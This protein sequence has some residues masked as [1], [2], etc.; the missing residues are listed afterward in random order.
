MEEKMMEEKVIYFILDQFG[1]S[2]QPV[3][4][5]KQISPPSIE[6]NNKNHPAFWPPSESLPS[7]EEKVY[8]RKVALA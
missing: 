8:C 1:P 3:P 7:N 2:H 6:E 4:P 5:S